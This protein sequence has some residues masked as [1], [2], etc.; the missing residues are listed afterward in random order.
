MFETLVLFFTAGAVFFLTTLVVMILRRAYARYEERYLAR[1]INDLS[2]MFFF[3]DEKQLAVL[4]VA[5]T[6]IG[7]TLGLLLFGPV[8]TVVLTILGFFSPTLLVRFYR[9]RR[10]KLFERQLVDAL[11]GMSSAFR[12]GLTFYQAM[13]E[14]ARV[15]PAPLA[16]EFALV[17]REMRL[18]IATEEA[19]ENLGK[20]VES[21]DLALVVTSVTTSRTLGG[22]LAE[23]FDTLAS[24]IRERFRI[25]GRVRALTAQGRLQGLII[26]AMPVLVW[27]G[28]DSIRPDL[29]RPM[30]EHWFGYTMVAV[31]VV[32]E[33]LGAFFISRIIAVR[34]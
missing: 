13:E 22:N 12:S 5:V 17:V 8:M 4:T 15:A 34:I 19:L 21:D 25:E 26:G 9:Q 16:Q 6:A 11:S 2:D 14:V 32:M 28:F 10:V 7:A 29:T 23:M 27:V 31:V 30:M 24:T 33:L 1:R 20:R 3:V 18:G